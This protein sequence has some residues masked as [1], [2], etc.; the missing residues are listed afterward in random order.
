MISK[1]ALLCALARAV[2]THS[3]CEKIFE[4]EFALDFVG[5]KEYRH[6]RN[7]ARTFLPAKKPGVKDYLTKDLLDQYFLPIVLP[8]NRFAED[9]VDTKQKTG[10]VQYVLLGAGLDSFALRN[11]SQNVDVF[12]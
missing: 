7:L 6:A 9:I 2:H 4:D 1:T 11:K 10:D 8:R 3:K 12:E 5:L